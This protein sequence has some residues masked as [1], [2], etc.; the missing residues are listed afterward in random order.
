MEHLEE[1]DAATREARAK[2]QA[3][4]A[5]IQKAQNDAAKRNQTSRTLALFH[6]D[7]TR[8]DADLDEMRDE[9]LAVGA[10]AGFEVFV[11][12]EGMTIPVG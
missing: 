12:A 9:A 11:A 2:E 7:P 8:T 10:R 5:T 3:R 1:L 6:H 4:F